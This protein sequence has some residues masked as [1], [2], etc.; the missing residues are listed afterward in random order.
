MAKYNNTLKLK[1]DE[2]IKKSINREKEFKSL[3]SEFTPKKVKILVVGESGPISG[4]YAYNYKPEGLKNKRLGSGF[5]KLVERY[6]GFKLTKNNYKSA[7]KELQKKGV[8][9]DDLFTFPVD[10]ISNKLRAEMLSENGYII[11]RLSVLKNKYKPEDFKI[12]LPSQ[13]LNWLDKGIMQKIKDKFE[14]KIKK[15][16]EM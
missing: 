1:I 10:F 12:F 16:S 5:S 2:Y 15:F 11:K 6:S 4:R 8:M 9:L 13:T 7:L 14:F 3:R